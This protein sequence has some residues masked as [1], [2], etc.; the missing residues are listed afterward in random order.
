MTGRAPRIMFSVGDPSADA[1]V[2]EVARS[3]RARRPDARL[4][5]LGGERMRQAGVEVT[6]DLLGMSSVGV[7]E[8]L[9]TAPHMARA[10]RVTVRG[11]ASSPPDC[12]LLVDMP[13]FNMRLAASA[14]RMGIKT[15][16]LFCPT[17]W[18]WGEWRARRLAATVDRCLCVFDFEAE[19]YRAAGADVELV[20]HPVIDRLRPEGKN[21][22]RRA[23]GLPREGTV[24]GMFPGSRAHEVAMLLPTMLR[25]AGAISASLNQV[26]FAVGLAPTIPPA[27][28]ERM[29]RRLAAHGPGSALGRSVLPAVRA[30]AGEAT[31][32]MEA[33][34]VG[35]VKCGTSTL[36][37]AVLGLPMVAVYRV[38]RLTAW[39]GRSLVRTPY[40]ALP[41]VLAGRE[42]V[43]E[44]IQDRATADNLARCVVAL[45]TDAE[46]VERM[47]TDLCRTVS[48]LGSA[49]A[50]DRI[51]EAV[52]RLSGVWP[53]IQAVGEARPLPT[54]TREVQPTR[55]G[56]SGA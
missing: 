3:I 21:A 37:A 2:A 1:C 20:G 7:L 32:V 12:L 38:S 16:Y 6:L 34:D 33:S 11:L 43:P 15:A 41:N 17:V 22:A 55:A 10:L 50:T 13:G 51:A 18:A 4:Y 24:V 9:R 56:G 52:L 31:R 39:V 26:T 40:F 44:L 48:R 42:V 45:L 36:E 8:S 25:A 46:R 19:C 30:F 5:G 47:R 29:L 23:L 14:H 53:A 54:E 27:L 49:G 28:F 35:M